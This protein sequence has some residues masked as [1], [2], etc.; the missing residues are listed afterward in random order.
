MRAREWHVV[1]AW[2]S[3]AERNG[4]TAAR[5][6]DSWLDGWLDGCLH[7]WLHGWLHGCLNSWLHGCYHSCLHRRLH[8]YLDSCLIGVFGLGE[9][10]NQREGWSRAAPLLFLQQLSILRHPSPIRGTAYS[11]PPEQRAR[12]CPLLRRRRIILHRYHAQWSGCQVAQVVTSTTACYGAPTSSAHFCFTLF[13]P[14]PKQTDKVL[15]RPMSHPMATLSH[16]Q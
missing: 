7:G 8:V 11:G 13:G 14:A 5:R 2:L 4:S 3:C 15:A 16:E 9:A 10:I 12:R 1:A 6:L